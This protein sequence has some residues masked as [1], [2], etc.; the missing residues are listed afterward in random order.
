MPNALFKRFNG[1]S[2]EEFKFSAYDSEKL[3]GVLPSGYALASH[4]HAISDVLTLQ[5]ALDGKAASVHGHLGSEIT[6]GGSPKTT[7]TTSDYLVIKNPDNKL[8]YGNIN[9][10][11]TH[12]E[13]YLR[14]D[15]T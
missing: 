7:L 2:W 13:N 1:T 5:T 12:N 8:E 11:A 4:S 9:F 15:G 14:R 10:N 3:G 6:I